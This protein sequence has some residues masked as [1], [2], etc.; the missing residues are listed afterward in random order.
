MTNSK[1]K[2]EKSSLMIGCKNIPSA[3][4]KDLKLKDESRS[5]NISIF[6]KEEL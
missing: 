1:V 5:F 3:Q 4:I 2:Y 6:N